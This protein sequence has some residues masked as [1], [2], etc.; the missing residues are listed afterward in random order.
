VYHVEM[1]ALT[2]I[3]QHIVDAP[4][5]WAAV[6]RTNIVIEGDTLARAPKGFDPAHRFIEDLKRKDLFS[7]TEFTEGEAVGKDFL[8]RFTAACERAAPLVGFVTKALE[9]RW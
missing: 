8:D 7:T 9:L 1:S 6:R 5:R 3:R 2:R 4:S